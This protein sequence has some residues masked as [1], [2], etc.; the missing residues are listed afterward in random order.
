MG[1]NSKSDFSGIYFS[2][3]IWNLH[4]LMGTLNLIFETPTIKNQTR[5][6]LSVL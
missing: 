3:H 2:D 6:L 1:H 4:K 5:L